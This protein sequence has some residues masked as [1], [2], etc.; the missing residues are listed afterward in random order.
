ME[1]KFADSAQQL[2]CHLPLSLPT[3]CRNFGTS[4]ENALDL[5]LRYNKVPT[6]KNG[7]ALNEY[8]KN[9]VLPKTAW[10]LSYR[11][12]PVFRSVNQLTLFV[13]SCSLLLQPI[14][15]SLFRSSNYSHI[16]PEKQIVLT[17]DI[18]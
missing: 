17:P 15:R 13:L 4:L 16:S 11:G 12:N 2:T 14:Y 5:F 10:Q 8:E 6:K 9:T 1:G 7:Q 18:S 3:G